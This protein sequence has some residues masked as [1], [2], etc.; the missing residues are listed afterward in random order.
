MT[1]Y[2]PA[3]FHRFSG[4]GAEYLYL[5]PSGAI[6]ALTPPTQAVVDVVSERPRDR[7]GLLSDLAA[8]GFP[9]ADA[10][11]AID[12]LHRAH[13]IAQ[14]AGFQDEAQKTPNPFPLQSIVLNVTNHCNLSCKYCYEFGEDRLMTT[15]GKPRFMDEE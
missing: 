2:R 3:G 7:A 12:E 4:G 1:E 5:A 8:R 15:E 9:G 13:A 10:E 6:F 11:E 14:G